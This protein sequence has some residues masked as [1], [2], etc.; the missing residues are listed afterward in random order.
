M[1]SASAKA[2][3]IQREVCGKVVVKAGKGII[4]NEDMGDLIRI[5]KSLEDSGVLIHCVSKAVKYAIIKQEDEFLGMLLGILGASM[6][7]N[8]LTGS[9]VLRVGKGVIRVEKDVIRAGKG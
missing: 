6:S 2:G 5:L 4:S 3:A 7:G 8:I 9:C 1:A